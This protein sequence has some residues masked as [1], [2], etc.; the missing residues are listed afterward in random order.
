MRSFLS[1][2]VCAGALL[3]SGELS[4]RRAPGFSLVD[5]TFKQHDPQDYRG[6]ILIVDIMQ[7][8]CPHC[9]TLS[10]VLEEVVAKYH[11]QVAVLSIVNPP[12]TTATVRR[13]VTEHKVSVPI[14][15][16]CGQVSASYFKATPQTADINVPHI[17]L[18]DAQGMIR[19]D[20]SYS[21]LTRGVF[22]GRDLFTELDHM[23]AAKK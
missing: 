7:T 16:D 4:G 6:K 10:G 18:I 2:L 3:A 14:L 21:P 15:F 20:Y 19:N 8:S 13:Y 1:M 23:L 9:V 5:M 12:D 22:E 17:F 11:G